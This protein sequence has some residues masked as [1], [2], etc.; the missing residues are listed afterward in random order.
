MKSNYKILIGA[1]IVLALINIFTIIYVIKQCGKR[2][3]KGD[4]KQRME[5]IEKRMDFDPEQTVIFEKA[6][7]E[8]RKWANKNSDEVLS[9]RKKM[10]AVAQT[11]DTLQLQELADSIGKIQ[12]N[13]ERMTALHFASI[14]K[15][16]TPKQQ[17]KL[18]RMLLRQMERM[19]NR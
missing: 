5:M 17:K 15:W 13:K 16:C 11:N 9:I 4:P 18:D 2:E 12:A 10:Y 1:I 7:Q 19:Q 3:K 8:H 14:R 6:Y